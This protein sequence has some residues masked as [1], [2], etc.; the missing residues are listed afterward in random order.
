MKSERPQ[1]GMLRC[2]PSGIPVEV[3]CF[4]PSFPSCL[5]ASSPSSWSCFQATHC[6]LCIMG[7]SWVSTILFICLLRPHHLIWWGC[8]FAIRWL[9]IYLVFSGDT[10]VCEFGLWWNSEQNRKMS[11]SNGHLRPLGSFLL[12]LVGPKCSSSG[13]SNLDFFFPDIAFYILEHLE[14][15]RRKTTATLMGISGIFL[16]CAACLHK[17]GKADSVLWFLGF[18]TIRIVIKVFI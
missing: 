14:N 8:I 18:M 15:C 5:S 6:L 12:P 4:L 16:F 2:F 17:G 3:V 7:F 13:S 10:R 9:H 11:P 1:S